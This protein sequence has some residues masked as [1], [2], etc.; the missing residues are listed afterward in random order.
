MGHSS[1][2]ESGSGHGQYILCMA[3][4]P[5]SSRIDAGMSDCTLGGGRWKHRS[6]KLLSAICVGDCCVG[7][8]GQ[9]TAV[10][11][12]ASAR[13][14]CWSALSKDG[15]VLECVGKGKNCWSALA[16]DGFVGGGHCL[17]HRWGWWYGCVGVRWRGT[18]LLEEYVVWDGGKGA[19]LASKGWCRW[20]ASKGWLFGVRSLGRRS[21]GIGKGW[22]VRVCRQGRARQSAL[23]MDSIVGVHQRDGLMEHV[24]RTALEGIGKGRLVGVR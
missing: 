11:W 5:C 16:R 18:A 6:R 20:S 17:G 15:V 24:E 3:T 21:E 12:S 4:H 1:E 7:V 22:L 2:I 8:C 23:V 13:R 19:S 9:G 10:C 14:L